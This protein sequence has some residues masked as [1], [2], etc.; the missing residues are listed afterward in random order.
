ML[1]FLPGKLNVIPIFIPPSIYLLAGMWGVLKTKCIVTHLMCMSKSAHK[2]KLLSFAVPVSV[3]FLLTVWLRSE[4]PWC[5]QCRQFPCH[6]LDFLRTQI[7][8]W[9]CWGGVKFWPNQP[10]QQSIVP[11]HVVGRSPFSSSVPMCLP[12]LI[13]IYIGYIIQTFVWNWSPK[14]LLVEIRSRTRTD[15]LS[16]VYYTMAFHAS[17]YFLKM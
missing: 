17:V 1:C 2:E 3:H 6:R 16:L 14:P 5:S 13:F 11:C 7:T 4:W 10:S 15:I 12:L 8:R 9:I